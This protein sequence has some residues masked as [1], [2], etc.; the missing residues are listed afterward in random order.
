VFCTSLLQPSLTIP[1]LIN[2]EFHS[3]NFI[4]LL[5]CADIAP[6]LTFPSISI[7]LRVFIFIETFICYV[8]SILYLVCWV[9][10]IVHC[11]S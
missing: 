5:E 3:L 7:S 9:G 2:T 8:F 6:A 11:A 4:Y 1:S 10:N